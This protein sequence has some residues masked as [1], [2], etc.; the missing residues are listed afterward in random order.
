MTIENELNV[1]GA[2]LILSAALIPAYL[3]IKLKGAFRIMTCALTTFIILHGIYH[4]AS[5]QDLEFLSESIVEPASVMA[6]IAFGAIYLQISYRED[7]KQETVK[8]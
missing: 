8:R 1:I 6:L 5:M 4:V 2:V 3:S 7:K